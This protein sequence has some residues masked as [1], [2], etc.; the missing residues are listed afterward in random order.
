MGARVFEL[1]TSAHSVDE[2]MVQ[3]QQHSQLIPAVQVQAVVLVTVFAEHLQLAA[4]IV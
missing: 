2:T 3:S 4:V 1:D